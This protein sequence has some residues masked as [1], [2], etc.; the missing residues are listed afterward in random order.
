[1]GTALN[2][3]YGCCAIGE[4]MV[5]AAGTGSGKTLA[6]VLPAVQSMLLEEQQGYVRLVSCDVTYHVV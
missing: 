1:M 3:L 5:L 6:Y 2:D 4:N